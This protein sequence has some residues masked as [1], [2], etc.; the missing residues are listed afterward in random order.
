MQWTS[1]LQLLPNKIKHE[2]NFS[3][4]VNLGNLWGYKAFLIYGPLRP[5]DPCAMQVQTKLLFI[6]S[7]FLLVP[8]F[9]WMCLLI[10]EKFA[11][12]EFWLLITL[13][14]KPTE[15]FSKMLESHVCL[16]NGKNCRP[17]K[18]FA[19]L[20]RFYTHTLG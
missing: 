4:F 5:A 9:L 20:V 16:N 8:C 11:F 7:V 6:L 19:E 1:S 3:L 12:I 13:Y 17:H 14:S 15:L 10:L 18:V 2:E